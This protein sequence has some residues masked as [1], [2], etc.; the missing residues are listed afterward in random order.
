MIHIAFGLGIFTDILFF[1]H[2]LVE[3]L[4]S[5]FKSSVIS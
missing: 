4:A 2:Q 1:P 3:S 5:S